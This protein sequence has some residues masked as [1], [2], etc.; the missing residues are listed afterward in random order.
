MAERGELQPNDIVRITNPESFVSDFAKKVRDRDGV[1]LW[2]G[3][4]AHG[5]FA[6]KAK[7][8]FKKRNGR[9]KEFE[10]I[11]YVRDLTKQPSGA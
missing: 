5:Q 7:I 4:L 3:P 8:R 10:E 1:V 2:V 6:N 11:L 9:G